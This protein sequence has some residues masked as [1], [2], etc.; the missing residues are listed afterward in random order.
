MQFEDVLKN[1]RSIRKF[2][3]QPVESEKVE[4]LVEA[5]RVC[6]SAKNRQ[7]WRLM[8][9]DGEKKDKVADIMLQLFE[10]K[11]IEL[12]G[13]VNSSKS[14]ATIIR[15]APLLILVFKEIDDS[16]TTGDLLSI[17]AAIEHVCLQAVAS[18]LGSLWIRDT[19]YTKQEISSYLGYSQLDLVSGIAIG[20]PD[21]KPVM[22][23]RK[24]REDI[25][26]EPK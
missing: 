10:Q 7:P 12:P 5:L 18:S 26:L 8:I 24:S 23:P 11:D 16:W 1:R 25:L 3:P 6:Q 15:E 22:R 21:E 2:Q 20:Y 4:Q 9:L 13:Y 14:S 17:G 19:E